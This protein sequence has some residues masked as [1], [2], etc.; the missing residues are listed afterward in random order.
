MGERLDD[1]AM[2]LVLDLSTERRRLP[3]VWLRGVADGNGRGLAREWKD[4]TK[5]GRL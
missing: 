4:E 2:L 3:L 1:V 5:T